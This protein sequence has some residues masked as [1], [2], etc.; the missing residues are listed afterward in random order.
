MD[1]RPYCKIT[2]RIYSPVRDIKICINRQLP[3]LTGVRTG[4]IESF[5]SNIMVADSIIYCEAKF[6]RLPL[7]IGG[8]FL[9]ASSDRP[10]LLGILTAIELR[11]TG[12]GFVLLRVYKIKTINKLILVSVSG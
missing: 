5:T 4:S 9:P 6:Y 8:A 10:S 12:Y 11:L 7:G 2:V 3:I 1:V